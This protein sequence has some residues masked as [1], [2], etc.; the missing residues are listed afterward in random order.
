[1]LYHGNVH[2]NYDEFMA[3]ICR[4]YVPPC[5]ACP[6]RESCT[7]VYHEY[8]ERRGWDEYGFPRAVAAGVE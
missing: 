6:L 7:G 4:E 1:M 2:D 8:V 5:G 3:E